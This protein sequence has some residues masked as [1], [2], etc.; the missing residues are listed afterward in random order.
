MT[1]T[2]YAAKCARLFPNSSGGLGNREPGV[3][4]ALAESICGPG[5]DEDDEV[6]MLRRRERHRQIVL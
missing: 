3:R 5:V 4:S 2:E 6:K 1:A